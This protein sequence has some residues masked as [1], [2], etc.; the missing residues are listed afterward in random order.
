MVN[1]K[2]I[3]KNAFFLYLRMFITM[4]ISL[5]TSRIVLRT[6]GETDFGIYNIVG[7]IVVLFSFLNA[8]LTTASQRYLSYA[9]GNG[10]KKNFSEYFSISVTCFIAIS[11]ILFFLTET[12]GLWF[13]NT[14]LN[15]PN[16]R[17]YAANIVYQFSILAFIVQI[18]RIPYHATII[19]YEKMDFFAIMSIIEVVLKLAIVYVLL[20]INVDKLILYS[21]LMFVVVLV[22]LFTYKIYCNRN[23]KHT[24]YYFCRDDNKMKNFLSFSTWSLFGGIA[25][26][27]SQQALNF[28]LNIFFGVTVNA[29]VGIANQV[30]GAIY[31]F[32]TNFQVAFNPQI[33]KS[34]ATNEIRECQNLVFMASKMSFFLLFVIGVPIIVNIDYILKLWL[35]N[36]PDYTAQFISII[37]IYQLID[38]VSMPFLTCIQAEGRIRNYQIIISLLILLNIPLAYIVLS[39]DGSPYLVWVTKIIV[40]VFCFIYRCYYV[41]RFVSINVLEFIKNVMLRVLLIIVICL[42]PI[43][44][45]KE[46]IIDDFLSLIYTSLGSFSISLIT[47]YI[48]GLNSTEKKIIRKLVL[49]KH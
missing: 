5:F 45:L 47:I 21:L 29:A 38:A 23:Y 35:G 36:V 24:K 30:M 11:I 3:A 12:L 10:D 15:I 17:L 2:K 31:S 27:G 28:M 37:F 16:E 25:N 49:F 32:V 1:N 13:L 22:I 43:I 6:L 44:L 9:L 34:Y 18:L 42:P 33:V 40:N 20:V 19:A 4:G 46:R 41:N 7:G 39:L 8:A 26:I 48:L 14:Y